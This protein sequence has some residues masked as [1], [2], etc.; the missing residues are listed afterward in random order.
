VLIL[1]FFSVN[2]LSRSWKK[3]PRVRIHCLEWKPVLRNRRSLLKERLQPNTRCQLHKKGTQSSCSILFLIHWFFNALF[4]YGALL[5]KSITIFTFS[6][7]C[8]FVIAYNK[9]HSSKRES[10]S[11]ENSALSD[12]KDDYYLEG[13]KNQESGKVF[14]QYTV[15]ANDDLSIGSQTGSQRSNRQSLSSH[16]SS[17]KGA[18]QKQKDT[19]S[20]NKDKEKSRIQFLPTGQD[21][22]R[23]EVL[24]N[25]SF[26][27]S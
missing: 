27:Q 13:Y 14:A 4:F 20:S 26:L 2:V 8:K 9:R 22:F 7:K 11:K 18:S 12:P 25:S 10:K 15:Q 17:N 24:H 16:V 6:I 19:I 23:K 21:E 3:P 5:N 1:I